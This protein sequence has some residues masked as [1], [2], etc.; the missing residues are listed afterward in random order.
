MVTKMKK[1]KITIITIVVFV[2]GLIIAGSSYAFWS[3]TSNINKN[4]VFNVANDLRNYIIYNEGNSTFTGELN[5]SNNYQTGG[6][7]S[8]I[9]IYKT[10]NVNLLA[11]IHMDINQIGPNMKVSSALKWVVTEGTSSNPGTV[12][13]KG[14]FIGTN[15]GDTLTL[16]PD[17]AVNT[18]ETFYTIWIWLDSSEN[19]S[20]NLSGETLD[21]NVWT[22]VNQIEGAEDRYEI[23]NTNAHYQQISA[24]V[25]DSKYKVT[26]YAITTTNSE[27]SSWTTI[28]PA[29]DQSKVYNLNTTVANSGSYYIWFK[30]ENDRV[31]SK[32]VTVTDVDTT[33]PS[34][35]WGSFT[36]GTIQNNITSTVTLT[37]TDSESG[38]SVYDLTTSDFTTQNNRIT[39]TNVTNESVTNGYKYTITVTGTAN[40]GTSYITLAANKVINGANLA[41]T[42]TSSGNVIVENIITIS[43]AVVTLGYTSTTYNGSAKTPSVTVTK[44]G[45]TLTKD[46]DYTVTY[47]NNTNVGTATVT[48][49]GI[50]NYGGETTR[51]F[52]ISY[53]SFNITLD[54][55]NATTN[56]TSTIYMRYADGVYL[57]NAYTTKMTT[58]ANPITIPERTGYTFDGYYDGTTQMIDSTGK[59]TSAFT[60]TKYSAAK[61]LNAGW[62]DSQAPTISPVT[63]SITYSDFSDWTLS[64]ATIDS[65]GYLSIASTSDTA[66]AY[67]EAHNV[68]WDTNY[69]YMIPSLGSNTS[70]RAIEG[71]GYYTNN[72]NEISRETGWRSARAV[73]GVTD[74]GTW[75]DVGIENQAAT[76]AFYTQTEFY[77]STSYVNMPYK[78]RNFKFLTLE[79][80]KS[81]GKYI[82]LNATDNSSGVKKIKWLSGS[83]T[84]ADFA[85]SGTTITNGLFE[86]TA[87]GTY[88][89]YVEDNAGNA[90]VYP[91]SIT[92]IDR[93]APTANITSTNT[94]T[95][96]QTA[97][98]T[99]NDSSGVNGYYWGTTAPSGAI[100]YTYITST[101]SMSV[102][103]TINAAGTYYLVCKDIAGN[104]STT[105]KTFYKTTLNMTNGTVSPT[106][107]ITMSGKSFN[108]PT[109][110]ASS[111]YTTKGNWYTNSGLTTGAKAYASSYTPSSTTTLYSGSTA[112]TYTVDFEENLFD[113]V[114]TT[115]NGVTISYDM[116]NSAVTINGTPTGTSFSFG[117]L[118]D[119]T[120]TVG[121]TYRITMNKI[122]GSYSSTV[123]PDFVLTFQKDSVGFDGS[124][125]NVHYKVVGMPSA[126]SNSNSI[127]T[128]SAVSGANTLY[129]WFWHSTANATTFNN[130]KV[131][132]LITKVST[133]SVT[134][135]STYGTLPTP[136][137]PGFTFAGWYT[138]VSGGTQVTSST[139]VSTTSN[140]KLY[141]RW[142]KATYTLNANANGGSIPTTSGWTID[143]GSATASK[144]VTYDNTY[145]TLPTP[146]RT[147]YDFTNWKNIRDYGNASLSAGTATHK[148]F[149]AYEKVKPGVTY[150]V[151][152]TSAQITSGSATQFTTLIYDFTSTTTLSSSVNS[153]GSDISYKITCPSTADR[154]HDIALIIYA[155]IAGSTT[156]NEVTYSGVKINSTV[157]NSSYNF[158]SSSYVRT[159]RNHDLVAAWTAKTITIQYNKN[160]TDT[161]SSMPSSSTTYTYSESGT[162]NLASNTPTRTGYTFLGWS[163]SSSATSASYAAGASWSRSNLPNSGTTYTLYAVWQ[164]NLVVT[165]NANGGS[166]SPSTKYV[167]YGGTYGTLPTPTRSGKTFTGWEITSRSWISNSSGLRQPAYDVGVRCASNGNCWDEVDDDS[168][169]R[170]WGYSN[171]D[172]QFTLPAGKYRIILNFYEKIT[173]NRDY[174]GLSIYSSSGS[175]IKHIRTEM[176][177]VSYYE[178]TFTLSSSTSLG[179]MIKGY[180][181]IYRAEI[182]KVTDITSSTT[183]ST[184]ANHTVTAHWS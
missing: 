33:A 143:S 109:P 40:D 68:N 38:I 183:V 14:N 39:V 150:K 75:H 142:T 10:T 108:L 23:T 178:T 146:T 95:T 37:C 104:K 88:T 116:A 53:N 130:Y 65:N 70:S 107:V 176:Y 25:V 101:T 127:T 4:V 105:S 24:T 46:T 117:R 1:K 55:A 41:N 181:S 182:Y 114:E 19:P 59:I 139:T 22:E 36:P 165:F 132:I 92:N 175:A 151:T 61:T 98:L 138:A 129:Y 3:W 126:D 184:N 12:L 42:S 97:T 169:D 145:G 87:T 171:A 144:S 125:G 111:G 179:V 170:G 119:K 137:K 94:V 159:P 120:I 110:T 62:V 162:T 122:S 86:A 82:T 148:Y 173:T 72:Y 73:P 131:Q 27:P 121:D 155:G 124:T 2:V 85:S 149:R 147:G 67:Y 44:N 91:L 78:I 76:T 51:T 166:V 168:D 34:C 134:Y 161:V 133:K 18:T 135:A 93:T 69:Q 90:A 102:T 49:T 163:T 35:S 177:N 52:T 174:C 156:G 31:T 45:T 63:R 89:I 115:G 83:H 21:T 128:T 113:D 112:N 30:D 66:Y 13:A 106:S 5:V 167:A 8:T 60:N 17:L 84:V 47:T 28:T 103:K 152:M 29:T 50:N 48:I 118:Y 172:W 32:A 43:D 123:T 26:H 136:T 80:V 11:T 81:Q 141:A 15:N 71:F 74:A 58:S 164:G 157:I 79:N 96:S 100:Q 160:T 20:D 154:T 64:G 57:D 56:G 7:H 77:W 180:N 158:T 16:V 153:F 54:N 6:I 140:H 9:S 99:C